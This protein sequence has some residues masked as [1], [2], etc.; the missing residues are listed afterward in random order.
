MNCVELYLT[1]FNYHFGFKD[2]KHSNNWITYEN[3]NR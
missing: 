3:S 2:F 1:V